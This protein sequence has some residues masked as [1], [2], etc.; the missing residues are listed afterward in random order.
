MRCHE[1]QLRFQPELLN[2]TIRR[3]IDGLFIMRL[4]R[5]HTNAINENPVSECCCLVIQI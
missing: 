5:K 1:P 4:D 2:K 3:I